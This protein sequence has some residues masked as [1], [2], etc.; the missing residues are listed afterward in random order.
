MNPSN[1]QPVPNTPA[2]ALS[3]F[4]KAK[5]TRP[6]RYL[7]LLPEAEKPGHYVLPI[8]VTRDRATVPSNELLILAYDR[9]FICTVCDAKGG[10]YRKSWRGKNMD[11]SQPAP[12]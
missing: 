12:R 5:P 11:L 7:W 10:Q 1:T 4:S 3:G 2:V 9:D 8:T 6:G